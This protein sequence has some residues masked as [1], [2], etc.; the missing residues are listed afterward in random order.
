[1][2]WCLWPVVLVLAACTHR[3]AGGGLLKNEF[4]FEG[5]CP[6]TFPSPATA[7][8]SAGQCEDVAGRDYEFVAGT[9]GEIH[10]AE[11]GTN[12]FSADLQSRLLPPG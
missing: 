8:G 2:R 9:F 10:E 3:F 11:F 4:I 1:M 7:H 6:F 12:W 5:S